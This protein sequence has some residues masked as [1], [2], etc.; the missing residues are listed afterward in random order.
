M[1]SSNGTGPRTESGHLTRRH[2]RPDSALSG[3]ACLYSHFSI[4]H[5]RRVYSVK[6][7]QMIKVQV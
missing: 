1:A 7:G 4:W 3:Y 2:H 6:Q 5:S